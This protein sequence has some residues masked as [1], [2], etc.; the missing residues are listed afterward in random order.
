M[1]FIKEL[2]FNSFPLNVTRKLP[3]LQEK[4]PYVEKLSFHQLNQDEKKGIFIFDQLSE[5]ILMHFRFKAAR[6]AIQNFRISNTMRFASGYSKFLIQRKL[7]EFLIKY[8]RSL[9]TL[10]IISKYCV[11]IHLFY[12]LSS[13]IP[14]IRKYSKSNKK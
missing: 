9:I 14:T 4:L 6:D 2:R 11:C 3:F 5:R 10:Q 1:V 8:N 7:S 13:L 12:T